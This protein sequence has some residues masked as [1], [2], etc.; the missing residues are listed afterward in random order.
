MHPRL[1][2]PFSRP[3]ALAAGVTVHELAGPRYQRLFHD[4]YLPGQVRVGAL[5]RA[6][7]ALKISVPG[8]FASHHTA[9]AIW[10]GWIAEE[11]ETHISV[12][13]P[14]WRSKRQGIR[15][16]RARASFTSVTFQGVLL[17]PPLQTF[18][19]LA[20]VQLDLV[21]LVAFGDSLIR[22]KRLSLEQLDDAA[23]GWTGSGARV[24]RRAAGLV[25]EGVDSAPESRL[26]MLVVL[27]GLPE[28]QVN[29]ITRIIGGEWSRRFDLCY[30]ALKLIIEYDGR[31]HASD[32]AQW[33]SDIL[34]REELEAQ[35]WTLIIVNADALFNHPSETLR[36]IAAALD[37][38]GHVDRPRRVPAV[39]SRHFHDRGVGG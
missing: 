12:P 9:A 14:G 4:L 22:S 31:Q 34:R 39:W 5:D 24:A 26:R 38:R 17:S 20:A 35:G 3:E 32:P 2:E 33:S 36:R 15:A 19:E 27:G 18:L 21:D 30:P 16:H 28:P 8:S 1:S 37:A 7:A 29:V 23:S 13:Y 25:R 10:G 6:R 11:P